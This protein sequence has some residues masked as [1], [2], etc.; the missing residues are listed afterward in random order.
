MAIVKNAQAALDALL[1]PKTERLDSTV[2]TMNEQSFQSL[3]RMTITP[4]RAYVAR[5]LGNTAHTD[6]I[7]QEAYLR[8][9][10]TPS[11]TDDPQYLRALLFRIAS[12]LIIDHFRRRKREKA[13][14]TEQASRK[15]K[16]DPENVPLRVDMSRLFERLRPQE[17]QLMWLAHVEGFDHREIAEALGLRERS[18]RVLLYRVRAK[19]ARLI[20]E[21]KEQ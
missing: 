6:D 4:L 18:V 13:A 17:R 7:V 15:E 5:V 20:R 2:A 19:L 21:G 3:H 9:M 1:S 8:I 16:L 14:Q 12:N 11:A 10:R